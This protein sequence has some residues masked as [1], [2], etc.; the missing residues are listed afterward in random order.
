[1]TLR[2][3]YTLLRDAELGAVAGRSTALLRGEYCAVI[4]A[5]EYKPSLLRGAVAG[6]IRIRIVVKSNIH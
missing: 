2:A 1:M 4:G 6:R 5:G 3:L